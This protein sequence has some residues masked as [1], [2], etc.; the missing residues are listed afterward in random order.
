MR[1]YTLKIKASKQNK[2]WN[3]KNFKKPKKETLSDL[4][5]LNVK[6]LC[7]YSSISRKLSIQTFST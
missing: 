6:L 5:I 7:N 3:Y 1:K 4:L 2:L